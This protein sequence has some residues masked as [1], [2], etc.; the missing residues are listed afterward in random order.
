MGEW[1]EMW[2]QVEAMADK[3]KADVA[4]LNTLGWSVGQDGT[5]LLFAR[6]RKRTGPNAGRRL[7]GPTMASLMKQVEELHAK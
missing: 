6:C 2:K 5:G 3:V 7:T 1:R 4:A